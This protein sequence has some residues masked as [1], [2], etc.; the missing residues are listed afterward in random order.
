[1][2]V[3]GEL[4]KGV[5]GFDFGELGTLVAGG[6]ED[7]VGAEVALVR[8]G[9]VVAGVKASDALL[10]FLRVV[11]GLVHPVPDAAADAGVRVFDDL[12]ILLEVADG[13]AHG[14][15]IFADEHRFVEVGSVGVHPVHVGVHLGVEV[16]ESLA[17]VTAVDAGTLIVNGAGGVETRSLIVAL[18]KVFTVSGLVAQTPNDNGGVVAVAGNLTVDAI[19]KS[20]NPRRHIGDRLVGVV[21]EVGLIDGVEAVVVEHGIHPCGVGIVGGADGVDVV[22]LHQKHVA[23][24]CF[25]GN[26]TAAFGIGV[27]AVHP[28]E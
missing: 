24:H 13:V 28:F 4:D 7:A 5:G 1:M 22:L 8:A 11:D 19:N 6:G 21:F 23:E 25:V 12:P 3:V 26:G 20:R 14:V 2:A 16:G 9:I 18:A 27:V 10:E 17:A 15:G